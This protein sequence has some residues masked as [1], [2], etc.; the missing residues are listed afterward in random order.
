MAFFCQRRCEMAS[1]MCPGFFEI[2][3]VPTKTS[4][5]EQEAQA[6]KSYN[7]GQKEKVWIIFDLMIR[8]TKRI[9]K[10]VKIQLLLSYN[11]S[12]VFYFS[13]TNT[14]T[15]L[16]KKKMTRPKYM[17]QKLVKFQLPLHLSLAFVNTDE[18]QTKARQK[19]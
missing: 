4:K 6:I 10:M 12:K 18:N 19:Y 14:R 15:R 7:R 17:T 8:E 2:G 16:N 5:R 13:S 9:L 3:F 11:Y 1:A